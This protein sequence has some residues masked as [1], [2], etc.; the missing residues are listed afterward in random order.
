MSVVLLWN[1]VPSTNRIQI[2]KWCDM[3]LVVHSIISRRRKGNIQ[4]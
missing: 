2:A 3:N 4:Y 1:G